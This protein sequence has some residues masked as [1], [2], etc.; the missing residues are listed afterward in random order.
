[1]ASAKPK[2]TEKKK[3]EAYRESKRE[4][5]INLASQSFKFHKFSTLLLILAL[6]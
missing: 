2:R 3:T 4:E 6:K 1:M 5:S